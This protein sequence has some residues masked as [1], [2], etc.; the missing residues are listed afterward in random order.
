[1]KEYI[2]KPCKLHISPKKDIDLYYT[3]KKVTS[4]SDKHITFID[5]YK[6]VYTFRIGDVVEANPLHSVVL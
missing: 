4:I 1:M 2:G 5:K 3:V 6:K